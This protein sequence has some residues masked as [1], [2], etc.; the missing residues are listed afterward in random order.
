MFP[1]NPKDLHEQ[2]NSNK[3]NAFDLQEKTDNNSLYF[4]MQYMFKKFGFEEHLGVEHDKFSKI[5]KKLQLGYRDNPY[6]NACHATDVV[7]VSY[8]FSKPGRTCITTAI[9]PV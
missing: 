2:M 8:L 7:Q 9:T 6:H 5:V 3:F 4:V 1:V